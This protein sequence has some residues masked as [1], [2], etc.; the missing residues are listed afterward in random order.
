MEIKKII[1]AYALS[2]LQ[3]PY[4]WGGDDFLGVDCSGLC[5][6]ILKAAGVFVGDDMNAQ[7]LWNHYG[8]LP[9]RPVDFGALLFFGKSAAEITHVTFALSSTHYL[10]AEGGRSTTTSVE[11][12]AKDN[13]FVKVR[14]IAYRGKP[15]AVAFPPYPW[16]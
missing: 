5:V 6:E 9:A 4:I 3:K 14:P 11:Q 7:A 1:E 15:V 16:E 10:G 2:F 13:A 12:A 8:K